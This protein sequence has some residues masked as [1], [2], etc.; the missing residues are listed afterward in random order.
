MEVNSGGSVH[1]CFFVPAASRC[2]MAFPCPQQQRH[3]DQAA[4]A[5]ALPAWPHC[6]DRPA[7][8]EAAQARDKR[9]DLRQNPPSG[10]AAPLSPAAGL[11]LEAPGAL[12]SCPRSSP[13][14]SSASP[15]G[16][17]PERCL[18]ILVAM[19]AQTVRKAH[20]SIPLAKPWLARLTLQPERSIPW[21]AACHVG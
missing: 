4:A 3:Q 21:S 13:S 16:R 10:G 2:R 18:C 15:A 17:G 12:S 11:L 19:H 7:S 20:A 5:D 1:F 14:R 9:R 6:A 8:A